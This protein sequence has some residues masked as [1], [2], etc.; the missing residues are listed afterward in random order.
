MAGNILDNIDLARLGELLQQARKRCGMTQADAAKV[1]DVARTTIVAIE[2]GERRLKASELIKLARAYGQ[3]VSH[4]VQATPII[5]PFEVQFRAAYGRNEAEEAQIEPSILRLEELCRNYL[6]IEEIVDAPLPQ[7]YPPEYQVEGMPIEVAAE[8]IATCERQRLGLGDAPIH[9][10]RDVLEQSVGLRIF[11]LPMPAKYSEIYSYNPKLGGCMAINAN[12]PE[13]R[14]R[15]SLA[16]GYLHFLAHRHR[17]VYDF[18]GQYQR[19]PE[20]ERLAEA[21]PKYFLMPT[22]SLLK[23]FNDLHRAH[24]KFT[25]TNLFTLAH[26]YGVS[27]EALTYR[28][29]E[30]KLL[31]SGT[32]ER[33]RDRGLKVRQVQ[34]EMGLKDIPQRADLT[35]IHY[36]HLAIDA[37]N[38]GLIT[39]GRFADLFGV[40]RLE[41]RDIAEKLRDY[42]SEILDD[43]D[44]HLDLCQA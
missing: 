20:S 38:Q 39:E 44:T 24:G 26:Y 31:S 29:E 36:Q 10:L 43:V 27:V 35:P 8:S 41:A 33:L 30:M 25:P 37:L 19:I 5:Q 23:Q 6:Q 28:L 42:G 14:R 1:I 32:W 16:H 17:P 3:Q 4:F 40:E 34:Q 15:W 18:D 21:F 13:E 2:K 9:Q 22:S 11:Y 12:H 7:N